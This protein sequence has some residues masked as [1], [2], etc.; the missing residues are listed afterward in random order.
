MTDNIHC[1]Q[2]E[3]KLYLSELSQI[4]A[5]VPIIQVADHWV[6][7]TCV[8]LIHAVDNSKEPAIVG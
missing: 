2:Y 7:L 8:W 4:T 1:V 5:V 3:T 6:E